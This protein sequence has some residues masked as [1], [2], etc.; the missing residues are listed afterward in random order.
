MMTF[1]ATVHILACLALIIVAMMQDS[2]GGGMFSSQTTSQSV[3][4]ATG[5]ANLAVT[6][7]KI[8]S[9][10][11]LSTCLGIA[12]VYSKSNSSVIDSGIMSGATTA[13]ASAKAESATTPAPIESAATPTAPTT[14]PTEP[15]K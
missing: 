4:G 15:K 2:K 14:P 7:T 8:L 1:L 6:M 10:I 3:L 11:V 13:P 9:A 5:G 12:I